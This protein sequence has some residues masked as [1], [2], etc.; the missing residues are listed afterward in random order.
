M[1][2]FYAN[3]TIRFQAEKPTISSE[4]TY[5]TYKI[6]NVLIIKG[7]MTSLQIPSFFNQNMQEEQ[8]NFNAYL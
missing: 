2:G 8:L 1:K 3:N 7:L 4:I 6:I 5:T